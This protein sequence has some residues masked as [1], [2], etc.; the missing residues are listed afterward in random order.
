MRR[1]GVGFYSI[2]MDPIEIT[3]KEWAQDRAPRMLNCATEGGVD[4]GWSRYWEIKSRW[5]L[6]QMKRAGIK[7]VDVRK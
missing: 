3:E 4:F 6:R 2:D 7:P 5:A 1:A